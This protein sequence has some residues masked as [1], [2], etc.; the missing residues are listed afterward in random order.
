MECLLTPVPPLHLVVRQLGWQWWH[1]GTI[2]S[3]S[4]HCVGHTEASKLIN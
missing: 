2:S 4:N 1:P 3:D